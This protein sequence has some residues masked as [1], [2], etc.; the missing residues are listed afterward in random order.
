MAD[1]GLEKSLSLGV[2]K[3]LVEP[4]PPAVGPGDGRPLITQA[5]SCPGTSGRRPRRCPGPG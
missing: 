4:G 3:R 5:T 1:G 2:L